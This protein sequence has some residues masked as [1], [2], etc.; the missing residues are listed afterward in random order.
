MESTIQIIDELQ[1]TVSIQVL[2]IHIAN[3]EVPEG[4]KCGGHSSIEWVCIESNIIILSGWM[5]SKIN[6]YNNSCSLSRQ[7]QYLFLAT[8]F[9]INPY[10]NVLSY[11]ELDD[12][13]NRCNYRY[14]AFMV[15]F[16]FFYQIGSLFIS[17][18]VKL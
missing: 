16:F 15:G 1:S 4:G 6:K 18:S 8:N 2:D 9:N 12:K 5:T 14:E 17:L 10:E 7:C 11:F 13:H 3:V